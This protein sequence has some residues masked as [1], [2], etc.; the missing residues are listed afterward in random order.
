MFKDQQGKIFERLITVVNGKDILAFRVLI[1]LLTNLESSGV[2]PETCFLFFSNGDGHIYDHKMA[3]AEGPCGRG[4]CR[5]V[6]PALRQ[7]CACSRKWG[8]LPG[9]AGFP[10][11]LRMTVACLLAPAG[12]RG[13]GCGAVRGYGH[14]T[15]TTLLPDFL[16]AFEGWVAS[17]SLV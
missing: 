2:P 14:N 1:L 5:C 16:S 12:G 4:S 3:C 8:C 15:K 10:T 6:L 17:F 13:C 11:T 7:D 9:R